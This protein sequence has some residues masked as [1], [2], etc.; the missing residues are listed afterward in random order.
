MAISRP[1]ISGIGRFTLER[2]GSS[3]AAANNPALCNATP[4]RNMGYLHDRR[5]GQKNKGPPVPAT[6]HF[7][8]LADDLQLDLKSRL[9]LEAPSLKQRLG[10]ILGILV[11]PRPLAQA[12]G[13]QILIV[14][15]L[16]FLHH[17]LKLRDCGSD[18]T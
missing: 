2:T 9:D 8:C 3:N 4:F 11:P 1:T 14:L 12:R 16:V 18:W 5:K 17:L 15:K 10:D 7:Q 13:P 6:P